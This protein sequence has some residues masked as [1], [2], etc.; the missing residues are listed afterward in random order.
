V[1]SDQKGCHIF[2]ILLPIQ[3]K[4]HAL[5]QVPSFIESLIVIAL[6][7]AIFL[8]RNKLASFPVFWPGQ[9]Q[10]LRPTLYQPRFL[11]S[12]VLN[13]NSLPEYNLLLYSAYSKN[14]D[15]HTIHIHGQMQFRVE[16]PFVR[17]IFWFCCL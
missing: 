13:L 17:I 3:T 10:H 5:C 16:S 1:D 12:K 6:P 8:R 15:R 2:R 7:F 11:S 4:K 14:S 9:K